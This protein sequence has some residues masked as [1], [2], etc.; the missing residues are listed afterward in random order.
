MA[1]RRLMTLDVHE[2]IRRI[3][4]GQKD[5]AI[6]REMG[7][8]RKTVAKY[9]KLA[10]QHELLEGPLPSAADLDRLLAR[11]KPESEFCSQPFKAAPFRP[12]IEELRSQGV[13]IKAMYERLREDHGY[14]GSYSAARRYVHHLAPLEPVVFDP[15][16][17]RL[18]ALG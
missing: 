2:I 10:G 14:E 9:H 11:E 1:G 5:R 12:V 15:I 17:E 16:A 18:A 7:T 13:E 4:A 8:A 3:R 6:A